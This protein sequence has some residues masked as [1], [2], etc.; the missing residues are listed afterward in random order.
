MFSERGNDGIKRDTEQW[1]KRYN[2]KAPEKG[3]A[4]EVLRQ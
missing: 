4:R 1:F 3:G 2:A